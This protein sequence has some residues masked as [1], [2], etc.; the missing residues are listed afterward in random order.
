[1]NLDTQ[2][3][4]G[5]RWQPFIEPLDIKESQ[6]II[7]SKPIVVRSKFQNKTY[8]KTLYYDLPELDY[9]WGRW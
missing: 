3:L 5:T 4:V 8:M 9:G 2:T 1:M 7:T 6:T